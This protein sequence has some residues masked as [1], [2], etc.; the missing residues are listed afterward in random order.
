MHLLMVL[1]FIF[2]PFFVAC[3]FAV[4]LGLCACVKIELLFR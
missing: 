4:F 2:V 3:D 1:Q